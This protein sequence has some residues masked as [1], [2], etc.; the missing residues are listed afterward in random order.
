MKSSSYKK[1]KSE[2]GKVFLT[3]HSEHTYRFKNNFEKQRRLSVM[4][5]SK[6]G[7]DMVQWCHIG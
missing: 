4:E 7:W 2:V 1:K 5:Y 6:S 3:D